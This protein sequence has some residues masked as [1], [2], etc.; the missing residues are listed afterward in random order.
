MGAVCAY[1]DMVYLRPRED[2]DRKWASDTIFA[3]DSAL[4]SSDSMNPNDRAATAVCEVISIGPG[5]EECPDLAGVAVGDVVCLPLWGSSKVIVLDQEIGLMIRFNGLAG[6]VRDLGKPTESIQAINDYVLT[7]R[8][9]EAFEKHLHGGLRVPDQYLDDGFPV[10]SGT[11][12]IVRVCLE[13]VVSTGGGHW[14]LGKDGRVNKL[15]PRLW[16]PR[17]KHGEL[18]GFN[19]LATCKFRRFGQVFRLVP[20]ED[21]GFGYDP[22]G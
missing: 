21:I 4:T 3:P 8:D 12:G 10:D 19:P 13:R 17:Q 7:R 6:V 15:N 2:L 14:E 11:E 22:E 16:K 1:E 20:F 18:V 9:R 5:S